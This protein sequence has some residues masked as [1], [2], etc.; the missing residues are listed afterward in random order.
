MMFIPWVRDEGAGSKRGT[1]E[2]PRIVYE[3]LRLSLKQWALKARSLSPPLIRVTLSNDVH[4]DY[5][6]RYRGTCVE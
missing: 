6:G 1:V 5:A 2:T 4:T 3:I